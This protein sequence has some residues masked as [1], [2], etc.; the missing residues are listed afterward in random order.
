MDKTKLNELTIVDAARALRARKITVRELYDSCRAAAE[1][2]NP[3]LNA[4]LELFEDTSASIDAAQK[5]IDTEGA[6]GNNPVPLLCGIPL[7]IKDN[8]VIEGKIASASSKILSNYRGTYDA[9][10]IKK[11]KEDGV[12][13]IG[14]TNMDEFAMGSSTEHSAFG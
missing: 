6:A 3:E 13:F 8:I 7:A 9:T 12:I 11:L 2:R 5:R 1:A 4:Y 10:V 14:R